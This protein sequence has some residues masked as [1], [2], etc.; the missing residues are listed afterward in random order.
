METYDKH[1]FHSM[2]LY[3]NHSLSTRG[4]LTSQAYSLAPD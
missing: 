1:F 3:D 2:V 4:P